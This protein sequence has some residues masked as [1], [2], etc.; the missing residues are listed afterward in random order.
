M[1]SAMSKSSLSLRRIAISAIFLSIALVLKTAFTI[2]I[3]LFGQNGMTVGISGIFS[4][5]PAILFGPLYGAVVSGLSDLLGYILKPTGPYMPLMTITAMLGGFMRGALWLALRGKSSRAMR[6]AVAILAAVMLVFGLS[7]FFML[8]TDGIDT[9]FYDGRDLET[10]DKSAYS[11]IG[12]MLITRTIATS[13]PSGNLATYITSVTW[14]PT[15]I[16]ILGLVLLLADLLISKKFLGKSQDGETNV[17]QLLIAMLISGLVV[18]T[19]N[20]LILREM[21]YSSWKLLPFGVIWIP[22]VIEEILANTVKAYFVAVLLGVFR[23]QP[24]LKKLAR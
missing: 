22:R 17:T 18:T 20:T 13:N 5:M 2:N 23:R 1:L 24:G 16:A 21:L 8:S 6:I 10:V 15:G 9:A 19:L 4:V 11:P 14:G 12:A 3:P 7:S